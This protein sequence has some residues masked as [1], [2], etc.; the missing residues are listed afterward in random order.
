M[1]SLDVKVIEP[2]KL[3]SIHPKQ[4]RV[5]PSETALLSPDQDMAPCSGKLVWEEHG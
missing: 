1:E 3:Y 2:L 4:T 5:S